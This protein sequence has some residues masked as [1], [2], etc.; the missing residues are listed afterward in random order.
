MFSGFFL[1][2]A[3]DCTSNS[4]SS[5]IYVSQQ[6]SQEFISNDKWWNRR[7]ETYRNYYPFYVFLAIAVFGSMFVMS[8]PGYVESIV[9]H[10]VKSDEWNIY[11]GA[12][13]LFGPIG[14]AAANLL[15]GFSADKQTSWDY[16]SSFL[17]V[18]K[19]KEWKTWKGQHVH[20]IEK[21]V[22]PIRK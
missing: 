1:F 9:M 2:N 19:W 13:K 11:Y 4:S 17:P 18:L 21:W 16:H 20:S 8:M 12:Q 3:L 7:W 14:F 5:K 6:D 22:R 15:A 10:A